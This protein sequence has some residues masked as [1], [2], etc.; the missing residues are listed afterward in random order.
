L[1]FLCAGISKVDPLFPAANWEIATQTD[2]NERAGTFQML[3]RL[4]K[5][6]EPFSPKITLPS[7]VSERILF[8]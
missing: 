1:P 5:A 4:Q 6:E 7:N 3:L 2:F 8:L